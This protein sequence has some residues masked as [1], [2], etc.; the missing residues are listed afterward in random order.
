MSK[1]SCEEATLA[2]GLYY[3]SVN[4][5]LAIAHSHTIACI[6]SMSSRSGSIVVSG[7][8]VERNGPVYIIVDRVACIS[9]V[10][11]LRMVVAEAEVMYVF[12]QPIN[13]VVLDLG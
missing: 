10:E 2:H 13:I 4:G 9:I 7:L 11:S 3:L 1:L 8:L 5:T 6:Y 12:C